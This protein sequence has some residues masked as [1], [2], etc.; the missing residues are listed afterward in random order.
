[1]V[2]KLFPPKADSDPRSGIMTQHLAPGYSSCMRCRTAWK[3]VEG[4]STKYDEHNGCFPL[5]ELCWADLA[6]EQRLPFY[7]VLYCQ[8][9][10]DA[11]QMGHERPTE[12]EAIEQ[13]VLGGK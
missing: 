13:A 5:C 7:F 3:F 12:W 6:P 4:H 9:D 1:M 11:G 10:W 2:K 8:W